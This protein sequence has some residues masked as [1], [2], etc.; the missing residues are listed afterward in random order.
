MYTKKNGF[1]SA[2]EA[3]IRRHHMLENSDTVLVGLSGG[4][5]S[6]ALLHCLAALRA[7]WSLRLVTAHINH[8]LR[9][10]T[11]VE[12]AAF[13]EKLSSTLEI[14]CRVLS[15]DVKAYATG[16][17]LSLQEA[18]REVR[19][20]FYDEVAAESGA[21]K[22][23]LGHHANDNAESILINLL[24]GTGPKGLAGIP[25]VRGGRIIRPLIDLEKK[26]ILQFLAQHGLE[27][28]LDDSNRDPKYLR[29][30]IRL[31]LLPFLE[32]RFDAKVVSPLTRL[33][34]IVRAEEAY[35]EE[36]V[37][38][39]FNNLV[40]CQKA[41]RITLSVPALAS[42]HRALLRRLIRH[43][44]SLLQGDLKRLGHQHVDAV[45]HLVTR[46]IPSGWQDLPHGVGVLRD[47]REITFLVGQQDE[48]P[49]FEYDIKSPGTTLIREI[50][51]LLKLSVLGTDGIPVELRG[52]CPTTAFFDLDAVSFPLC[53]R[54]F[55]KGDRFVPL[56][57][58]GSQKVKD[59]FIN[60]KVPR[61]KRRR[62]PM[63]LSRGK[64]VW[65]GGHRIHDAVKVTERTKQ[66]LK[67][68]LLPA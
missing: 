29:N 68:E 7:D 46:P 30:R 39:I 26:D 36:H 50:D 55:R 16:H 6:V 2:V 8:Q 28:V 25:P 3:T 60:H 18:A 1:L 21:Q 57:M 34:S 47:G 66:V 12:E 19:Y 5:D 20:A 37:Q 41:D 61:S 13:V 44:L 62:S 43:T 31:E 63:V 59:F 33:A 56:G 17:R 27:Y 40:L 51:T 4:P 58:S 35:W 14:P 54:S 48:I 23:A 64:I 11:A 65:V 24:R 53:L 49:S 45:V 9:G 15:K 42:L 22:I 52:S 10:D 32:N 38:G 67:A